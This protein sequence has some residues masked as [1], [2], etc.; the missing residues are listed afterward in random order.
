LIFFEIIFYLSDYQLIN[1]IDFYKKHHLKDKK[2]Q[3]FRP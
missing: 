3:F 1:T 2:A